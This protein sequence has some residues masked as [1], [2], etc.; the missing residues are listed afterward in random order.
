VA[1]A[2]QILNV[3]GSGSGEMTAT[4]VAQK[5][6]TNLPTVHRFLVTLEEIGAVSRS[7]QGRFQLG[8]VLANL[9]DKVESNKM[10]IDQVQTHLDALAAE[11]REVAHCAVQ[12]GTVA[13]NIAQ[14]LPDRSLVIGHSAGDT[15]PLHCSAVGKVLLAWLEPKVRSQFLDQLDLARFTNHTLTQRAALARALDGVAKRGYALEDEEWEEGLQSIAVPVRNGRGAVVAALAVSAPLSRLDGAAIKRA[16]VAL[17]ERAAHL[18]HAMF[19]ESLVFPQQAR[20]RGAFPHLKRVG[21]FV[22]FSGTSARRPDDTFEGV[23][24]QPDGTVTFDIRKQTRVVFENIRVMLVGIGAS[25]ENL[26]DIQA[27]L[28]DMR[29]YDDF[30][31]TYAEFF[32]FTGPTRTTV[33]VTE[34][35]HPHQRLMVRAVAYVPHRLLHEEPT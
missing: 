33:G 22:F 12:S 19:T 34:L 16:H 17:A 8:L 28:T 35:P 15:V 2:F 31:D 27:Y 21:D 32:S 5:L 26:V 6:R 4:D 14:A 13:I 1:K 9:G 10:L 30:N 11:F 25:L 18:G 23:R 20:P 29:D 7:A 3:L 24:I